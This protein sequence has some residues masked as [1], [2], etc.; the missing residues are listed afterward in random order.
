MKKSDINRFIEEFKTFSTEEKNTILKELCIE[1]YLNSYIDNK[2][3]EKYGNIIVDK[4]SIQTIISFRDKL[5]ESSIN[6]LDML[7]SIFNDNKDLRNELLNRLFN[8]IDS[9]IEDE[10]SHVCEKCNHSFSEWNETSSNEVPVYDL[11]GCISYYGV[12]VIYSRTC[13]KCGLNQIAYNETSK[14]T[15][16]RKHESK[17][18]AK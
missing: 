17:R 9:I 18:K 6:K 14:N 16:T 1:E 2:M 7:L 3:V 11:D 5:K 10:K 13:S 4:E 12:G 15:L 8:N